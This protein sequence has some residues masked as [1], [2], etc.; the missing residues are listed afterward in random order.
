MTQQMPGPPRANHIMRNKQTNR[1]ETSAAIGE[2]GIITRHANGAHK[3][4]THTAPES[5]RTRTPRPPPPQPSPR[6]GWRTPDGTHTMQRR[7]GPV[8][9]PRVTPHP[10]DA[11]FLSLKLL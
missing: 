6:R 3:V 7:R 11:Y 5:F 4:E 10:G 8:C 9:P 1:R 2:L